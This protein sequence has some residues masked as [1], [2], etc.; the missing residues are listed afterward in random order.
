MTGADK[1]VTFGIRVD[2]QTNADVTAKSVNELRASISSA[3]DRVRMYQSSLRNL[4]GSS[5]EV[6]SAKEQLKGAI[7]AERDAVSRATL[8][9][10]RHGETLTSLT[11]IQKRASDAAKKVAEDNKKL[12]SAVSQIGGPLADAKAKV[13]EWGG[14]LEAVLTPMG[15]FV[16]GAAAVIAI[17]SAFGVA[18]VAG[19]AKLASFVLEEGNALRT[20]GLFREAA[21]GNA[22]DARR[23]GNQIDDLARRLPT[24][25][26]ELNE[27]SVSLSKSLRQA[28]IS[29]Q[30]IV[31]TFNA[32]AVTSAA[33]GAQTGKQIE[34]VITRMKRWGRF[35]LNPQELLGTGIGFEDVATRLSKNLKIGLKDAQNALVLGRVSIDDGAKAIREVVE[36]RFGSVNAK[37]MLDLHV[38]AQKLREDFQNLTKGIDFERILSPI[39]QIAHLFSETTI[40]GQ[41]LKSL[42][43]GFGTLLGAS[44]EKGVP[45]AQAAVDRLINTLLKIGIYVLDNREAVK[46]WGAGIISSAADATR[47]L[48]EVYHYLASIHNYLMLDFKGGKEESDKYFALKAIDD[49]KEAQA[50]LLESYKA[51]WAAQGTPFRDVGASLGKTLVDGF[52]AGLGDG[53]AGAA[54]DAATAAKASASSALES[55]SPSKAFERL[56]KGSAQGYRMG[57]DSETPNV[58]RSIR[59][60]FTPPS[61]PPLRSPT[62]A[63]AASGAPI[64]LTIHAEFPNAKDGKDVARELTSDGLRAR[65]TSMIEGLNHTAGVPV[66]SSAQGSQ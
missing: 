1:T 39:A 48:A 5:D 45:I 17:L 41:A 7:N 50:A 15:A 27:L 62:S 55:H 10:G 40:S 30:G 23:F 4:R 53:M 63:G 57:V 64:T 54:H 13:S 20:M 42:L 60:A 29:G 44:F 12:S 66:H 24:P 37:R 16:I 52:T 26:E 8:Q 34:D 3:Q 49:K 33:M 58:D 56:G 59:A 22:D 65:L 21:L 46:S 2:A 31:D 38:I 47:G 25:R 18:L 32:V 19:A 9:I 36:R 43:T 6:K 51:Q 11:Q 35:G 61:I 14:V 28:R